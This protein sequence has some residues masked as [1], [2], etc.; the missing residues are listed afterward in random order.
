MR[1]TRGESVLGGPVT[2]A[3]AVGDETIAMARTSVVPAVAEALPSSRRRAKGP[4]FLVIAFLLALV[5][6]VAFLL[7][8]VFHQDSTAK[9]VAVRDVV[10]MQVDEARH[11]LEQQ[12]FKVHAK[13]VSGNNRPV[14]EV[15]EQNPQGGELHEK[16]TTVTLSVSDG[17]GSVKVPKVAGLTEAVATAKLE[18]AGLVATPAPLPSETVPIGIVVR[19]DPKGATRVDLGS[20]VTIFVSQGP[21]PVPVPDVSGLDQVDATSKLVGAGFTVSKTL[22]SSATVPAGRVIRTEPAAGV[23]QAK[24]TAVT[25]VVSSGP[26]QVTVPDVV[27]MSQGAATSAIEAAGLKVS[28]AQTVSTPANVGKVISQN[29]G[30]NTK[31][32]EGTAVMITVGIAAPTTTSSTPATSS[33][34]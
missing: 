30:G 18:Q 11:V 19:S 23:L 31:A 32:E 15:F 24:N 13:R 20:E 3:V 4:V 27:G 25:L 9:T 12:G 1:F 6:V 26:K 8:Q 16:G 7:V 33:T 29:P 17:T 2:A 22:E 28:V 14:G 5:G 21:A 10:G 34:T